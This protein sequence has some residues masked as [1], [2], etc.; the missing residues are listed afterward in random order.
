MKKMLAVVVSLAMF[1]TGCSTAWVST[2]DCL[3]A[4]AAPALTNILQIAAVA[5]GRPMNSGL[6]TK[7]SADAAAIKTLAGDFA[8]VSKESAPGVC[9][10]LTAALNVYESDQQLVLQVAQVA[11]P[12]TQMKIK[13]LTDLVA[14]TIQAITAVIPSCG[15]PAQGNKVAPPYN[16]AGFTESY[17]AIL[18]APTGNAAVDA[19]TQN[20]KLHRH[21]AFVRAVTLGALQ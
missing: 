17:N 2:L 4:A 6:A 3:L 15:A 14:S 19:A 18:V 9:H 20:L 1:C 11:D 16:V 13:L 7:I 8:R 10:A 12:A 5:N 21:S